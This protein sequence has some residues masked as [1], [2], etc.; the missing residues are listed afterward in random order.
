MDYSKILSRSVQE[1]QPSGIRKFFDIAAEMKDIVSLT[2]GEPDFVTPRHIRDV[3]IKSL[4]DG[5][6]H[7]TSNTGMT[8]L[9]KEISSYLDRR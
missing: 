6:T 4:Q 8:V 9:R 5:E 7:Y 1:I 3:A 2:V